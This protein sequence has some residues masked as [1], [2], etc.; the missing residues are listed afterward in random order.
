LLITKTL[1]TIKYFA[2]EK[3][4]KLILHLKRTKRELKL[5]IGLDDDNCSDFKNFLFHNMYGDQR[6]YTQIL[7]NFVSNA[8]KFTRPGGTITVRLTLLETQKK[9]LPVSTKYRRHA[10]NMDQNMV[11][12]DADGLRKCDTQGQNIGNSLA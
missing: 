12:L 1:N 6:R 9:T 2:D 8:L 4:I 3:N 11:H 7:L 10:S 5:V